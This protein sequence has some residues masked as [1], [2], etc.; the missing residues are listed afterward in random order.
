[1]LGFS[2]TASCAIPAGDRSM[3]DQGSL[4]GKNIKYSAVNVE[5][6]HNIFHTNRS[7]WIKGV[8]FMTSWAEFE[9]RQDVW[10]L[11]ISFD[12]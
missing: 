10:F 9:K 1:M 8:I 2:S 11:L 7:L 6:H 4:Q 12:F 3:T 5:K